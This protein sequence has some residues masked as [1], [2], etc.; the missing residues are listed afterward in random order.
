MGFRNRA[1][2]LRFLNQIVNFGSGGLKPVAA[3]GRMNG[4]IGVSRDGTEGTSVPGGFQTVRLP[5]TV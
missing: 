1:T 2:F 4:W 5:K 3:H